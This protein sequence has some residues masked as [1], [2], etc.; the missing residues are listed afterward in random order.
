MSP[1]QVWEEPP[2]RRSRVSGLFSLSDTR[3]FRPWPSERILILSLKAPS[4]VQ[5][6]EE[7]PERRSRVSG[8]FSLSIFPAEF[9]IFTQKYSILSY[10]KEKASPRVWTI[11][12]IISLFAMAWFL[13]PQLGVVV[14][15]ALMSFIFYPLYTRLKRKKGGA[16]AVLTLAASFLV[17][18]VPIGFITIATIGQL[19]SFAETASQSQHWERIP[20][21]IEK[22]VDITNDT[23]API[24]G[25]R[26]SLTDQGVMNF[27][28][29]T[30]PTI[31]RGTVNFLLNMLGG[32]P[33]L[34]IALIIYIF[35]FVE[36]LRNGV[37]IIAKIE[38]L[39]PFD[40]ITT[41]QYLEK[42]GL[43][44]KAMVT[45]QLIISMIISAI[46]AI[47]LIPLG[48]GYYFFIFFVLFTVLNF[49]PLGSGIIVVPLALYSMF[50]G[51]PWTSLAVIILYYLMGNLDPI[52][53]ARLIPEKIQLSVGMTMLATFCG[54]AYFGI[55]GVVYGPIIMIIILTTFEFY[56]KYKF[57]KS[58]S[59]TAAS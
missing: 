21:F 6:W 50:T 11:A 22:I 48:Y 41:Q 17:V 7:P 53:R 28:R 46:A 18:L 49:I 55:L 38:S 4:P 56:L 14:F 58:A 32:L 15:T 42:I 23:L 40:K 31:A 27:L 47:L 8:L 33:Q 37:K 35:L 3:L 25:Q 26:P 20:V 10:M 57:K 39:S 2:E 30:V 13:L 1:V 36:F 52:L 29:T 51:Q 24:T 44:A 34:G 12:L 45:G 5:V 43:M 54:I 16:A 59:D 9:D 19:A